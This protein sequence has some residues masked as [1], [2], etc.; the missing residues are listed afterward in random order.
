MIDLT[1]QEFVQILSDIVERPLGTDVC[2]LRTNIYHELG[3]D[4]LGAVALVVELR[5]RYGVRVP[6][7]D[8]PSLQT[9]ED[10]IAY[11]SHRNM[12]SR[13]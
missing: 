10:F 8:I 2:G 11:L 1:L 3:L 12:A 7:N 13:L 4:S 6:D 5:R 9:P